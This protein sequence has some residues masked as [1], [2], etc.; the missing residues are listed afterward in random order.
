MSQKPVLKIGHLKITDHLALGLTADKL[1]RGQE[2][3]KYCDLETKAYKGWNPL[4]EELR[5]GQLDGACILA[6]IG[7]ELFHSGKKFN[8]VLQMHKN[9]STI[10]VNKRANINK[11]DDF[12]GKGVLIPH[13]LSMHHLLFDKLLRDSGLEIGP[14]KDLLFDVVAPSE[15][16]EIIEWD[17]K[18]TVGGFIVAEPF[19]TQVVK[20]GYGTEFKLS[21]EIWNNHPCCVLMMKQEVIENNPDGV[22]ELINSLVDSGKK[23]KQDVPH[24]VEVGVKFLS[25]NKEVMEAVLTDPREKVTFNEMKPVHDDLEFIQNYL[26]GPIQALSGKI[27]LE[28]FV[29]M[30]FARAAGAV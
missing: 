1:E 2:T 5:G 7:M 23:V 13:Y 18:G 16:L 27:D 21:R 26:T 19:G 6:P 29:D 10:V 9:G 25:Q 4:S 30:Q 14:G 22:H 11:L 15:I 12:K 24:A 17:E 3:F 28:K 20:E 8:M